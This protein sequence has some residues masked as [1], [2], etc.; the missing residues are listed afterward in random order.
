MDKLKKKV[1]EILDFR[2]APL[3]E[4]DLQE[5]I[6]ELITTILDEANKDAESYQL[7]KAINRM[8]GEI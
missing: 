6:D 3:T 1:A 5:G 8:I 4:D 2:F 7:T